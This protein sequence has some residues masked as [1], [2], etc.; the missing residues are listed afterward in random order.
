MRACVCETDDE[1]EEKSRCVCLGGGGV[2]VHSS[3]SSLNGLSTQKRVTM[4]PKC[5]L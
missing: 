3:D 5:M 1:K 2:I 4:I